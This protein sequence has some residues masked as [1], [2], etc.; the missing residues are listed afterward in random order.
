MHLAGSKHGW[1]ASRDD[2]LLS[3]PLAWCNNCAR[4]WEWNCHRSILGCTRSGTDIYRSDSRVRGTS[5]V[6][7]L[8]CPFG[9]KLS[10]SLR[11]GP[12]SQPAP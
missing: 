7:Q 9:L 6:W 1:V 4:T 5:L 3:G 8:S 11:R 10:M 2:F 12:V